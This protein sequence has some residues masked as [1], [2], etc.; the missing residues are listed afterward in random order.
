M[1]RIFTVA[2]A[3]AILST[4][5]MTGC[6]TNKNKGKNNPV[7][8][9]TEAE[10]TFPGV[11]GKVDKDKLDEDNLF[12]IYPSS[13]QN[14]QYPI[15]SFQCKA[16]GTIESGDIYKYDASFNVIQQDHYE[17]DVL[18]YTE[19][20]EYDTF[21]NNT[22]IVSYAGKI[23]RNNLVSTQVMEYDNNGNEISSKTYDSENILI[24][25]DETSYVEVDGLYMVDLY[26]GF[27]ASG[28]M[29]EKHEYSYRSDGTT[30]KD[31]RTEYDVEGHVKYYYQTSYDSEGNAVAY[32]YY[33]EKGKKIKTPQEEIEQY[34]E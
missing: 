14:H 17:G 3:V 20:R 29:T 31:I 33:N 16:D 25:S 2:I 12:E 15:E 28:K 4:A 32:D 24:A 30:S 9:T 26:K 1:K 8:Q 34:G 23:D 19:V 22:K 13:D 6:T 18:D 10:A 11:N 5:L 7:Q 21:N 27:D